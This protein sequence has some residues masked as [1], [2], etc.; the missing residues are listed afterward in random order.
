LK[1]PHVEE[2]ILSPEKKKEAPSTQG[3]SFLQKN[4]VTMGGATGMSKISKNSNNES[5]LNDLK[6]FQMYCK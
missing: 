1:I 4:L 3:A 5:V 6:D 2:Q